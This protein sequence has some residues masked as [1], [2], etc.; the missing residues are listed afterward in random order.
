MLGPIETKIV[1]RLTY[2]KL[3][4]VKAID[5]DR[6][7]NLTPNDRKQIVFRL[8]KKRI[9]TTIKPGVYIFSPLESGPQGVSI[10]ELLIPPLFFPNNNYYIGYSTMFNYYNL[11][12]QLFQTVYVINSSSSTEKIINGISYKFIKVQ[13]NKI[14]GIDVLKIKETE[15]NISS[16]ERTIIDLLVFN[17]PVGGISSASNI[18]RKN[19]T[20]E[21][22]NIP[23]LIDYASQY[24]TI[25]IRKLIGILLERNGI[26]DK[27]L[28]PLIESVQQTAISSLNRSRKGPINQ[29]WKV[30]EDVT[31][32]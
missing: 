4:I 15:I 21:H 18:F 7:F 19:A 23:K 9:L 14:Y 2:E 6:I 24:P 22:C 11:T 29:K 12:E 3:S 25:A 31:R 17:K 1:A 10:N 5:L 13:E 32:E 26:S 8:K 20:K 30:I 16:K 27:V 28:K